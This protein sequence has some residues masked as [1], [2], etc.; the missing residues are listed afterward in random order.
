MIKFKISSSKSGVPCLWEQGGGY[1]ATGNV[2]VITD[3]EGASK[4]PIYVKK[5]GHL[6]CGE[7]ALIPVEVGDAV[8]KASHHNGDF[9]I[10]INRITFIGSVPLCPFGKGGT[11]VDRDPHAHCELIASYDNGQW[12]E[13]DFSSFSAAIEAAKSK[14]LHYHCREPHYIKRIEE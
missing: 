11:C 13:V 10:S 1:T 4:R 2:V 7:H 14:A 5:R 6:A 12:D 8:I 3:K 9:H